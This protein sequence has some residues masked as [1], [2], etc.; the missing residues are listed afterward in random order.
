M[1]SIVAYSLL[2]HPTAAMPAEPVVPHLPCPP[3]PAF[4]AVLCIELHSGLYEPV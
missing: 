3:P 2:P 4:V 1:A